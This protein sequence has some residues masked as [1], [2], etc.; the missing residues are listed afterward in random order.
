MLAFDWL[1][2]SVNLKEFVDKVP[3]LNIPVGATP[4]R[5]IARWGQMR[6]LKYEPPAQLRAAHPVLILPSLINRPYV[7]DL[8]PGKSM[9]EHFIAQGIQVYL[10][11]WG[12]PSD[13][14]RF[15]SFDSL[16]EDRLTYFLEQTLEDAGA[17]QT[18]LVG[19]CLG[20]TLACVAASLFGDKIK[21]LSLYTTPVHFTAQGKLSLWAK[22]STFD[23]DAFVEAYGLVPWPLLQAS[24]QMLKPTA[25]YHKT[26]K[27][28]AKRSDPEFVRNFLALEI[29]ASDNVS[30]IGPCYQ[31]LITDLYREDRL[32]QGELRVGN[33]FVSLKNIHC[34]ILNVFALDDDIV[35]LEQTLKDTDINDRYQEI[36]LHGGHVGALIGSKATRQLWPQLS[37]WFIETPAPSGRIVHA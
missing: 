6:L 26:K 28:W 7:L 27:L 23:V 31:T 5:E 35:L 9:I 13:E 25:W 22:H 11:E 10:L 16:V 30:F 21:S 19:H 15:L 17:N 18:H 20:G 33:K 8:L 36:S 37:S 29:W 1:P 12:R 32:A 2:A 3:A 34:P 24:F 14:D 4:N